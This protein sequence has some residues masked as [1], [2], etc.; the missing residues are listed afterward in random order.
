MFT[1]SYFAGRGKWKTFFSFEDDLST[2]DI[3]YINNNN[4]YHYYDL[5]SAV[6]KKTCKLKKNK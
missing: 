4:Q 2:F 3:L 5:S 1:L 6:N